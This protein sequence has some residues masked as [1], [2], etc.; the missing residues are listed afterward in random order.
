MKWL[1]MS[2]LSTLF[3]I[4]ACLTSFGQTIAADLVITNANI[5]T[6]D[7]KRTVAQSVAV[8]NGKIIAIGS[9]ADTRSMIGKNTNVID[10]K[11]KL[12][13]PGFNDAHVHFM[14]T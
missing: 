4:S 9:D 3:L 5:R 13:L 8:L 7:A 10:A 11:G 6:M 1:A 14:G 12:V 2:V